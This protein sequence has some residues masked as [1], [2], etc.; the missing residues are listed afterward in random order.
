LLNQS[1]NDLRVEVDLMNTTRLVELH[2]GG[3][4]LLDAV[5]GY[6]DRYLGNVQPLRLADREAVKAIDNDVLL[7]LLVP[8]GDD[9]KAEAIIE[10]GL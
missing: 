5:I 7:L 6:N 9:G 1:A 4:S 10:N 2:S 8:D 3:H